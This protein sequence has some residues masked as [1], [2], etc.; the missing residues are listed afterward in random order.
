M[1]KS[2]LGEFMDRVAVIT[3]GTAGIGRHLAIALARQGTDVFFCGRRPE[4]GEETASLCEGRGHYC[5]SDAARPDDIAQFVGTAMRFNGRIDYLINNVAVDT[6]IKFS[7]AT[8]EEFDH[9]IAVNLRSAFAVTQAALPGLRAGTGKSVVNVGTTNYMLGLAPF[10]VYNASKAGL[11]GFTRSLARELGPER[12]RVNMLSPGWIMTAKQ[13]ELYVTESDKSD[14]LRDQ[15]LPF[16]LTE[17]NITPVI[18]FLLSAAAG[19]I[20]GQNIVVDGGKV[21]Q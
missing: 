7:E 19:G 4:Q 12:I 2:R 16:L 1:D 15:A 6:R 5:C 18:L 13:L 3:G 9:L 20:T 21:M 8:L 11:L 17:E 10:T 14:L